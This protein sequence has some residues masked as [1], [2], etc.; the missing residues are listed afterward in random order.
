MSITVEGCE[1][2]KD[3]FH[4]E[5]EYK[6]EFTTLDIETSNDKFVDASNGLSL[7]LSKAIGEP[8]NLFNEEFDESLG[9]KFLEFI[10]KGDCELG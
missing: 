10:L 6:E 9:E 1:V 5:S 8:P 7:C 4:K 3:F 2:A